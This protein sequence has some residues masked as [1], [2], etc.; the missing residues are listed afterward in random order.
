MNDVT[1]TQHPPHLLCDNYIT[2]SIQKYAVLSHFHGK[3]AAFMMTV[4]SDAQQETHLHG[5]VHREMEASLLMRSLRIKQMGNVQQGRLK[6]QK[7]PWK[8]LC[9][10]KNILDMCL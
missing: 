7:K 6:M 8:I 10:E 9:R 2:S 3:K 5:V 4:P 1:L